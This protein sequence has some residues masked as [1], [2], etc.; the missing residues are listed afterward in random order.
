MKDYP[1]F[2]VYKGLQKPLIFKGFKG[3]FIYFGAGCVIAGLVL[4]AVMSM[5][6]SFVWGGITLVVVMFGGLS[7][8]AMLQKKGLHNKDKRKGEYIVTRTFQR[9]NK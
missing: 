9:D 5:V 8:T 4:C 7:I 6:V 2:N 1:V 3:K